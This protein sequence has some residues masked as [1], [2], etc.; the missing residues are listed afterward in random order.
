MRSGGVAIL[1]LL[2]AACTASN[3]DTR[4]PQRFNLEGEWALIAELSDTAP[5]QRGRVESIRPGELPRRRP[6]GGLAF[7]AHDFP[8]IRARR[9]RIEQN[10]DSMGIEYDRGLYRDISWGQ[11]ERGLWQVNAGWNE[12]GQLIIRSRAADARA[13]E[14]LSLEADGER[15]RLRIE[16]DAE[17]ESLDLTRVYQRI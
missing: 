2:T 10:R 6:I 17:D 8:S 13:V 16:I 7:V 5:Q 4:V 9:M 11:R 3:L 15:L 1:C 14:T 12:E